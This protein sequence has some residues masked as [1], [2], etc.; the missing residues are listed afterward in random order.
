MSHDRDGG[1]GRRRFLRQGLAGA[2]GLALVDRAWPAAS[3]AVSLA[4]AE[5]APGVHNML[6]VGEDAVFLSHLPMFQR[7]DRSGSE[8]VSPAQHPSTPRSSPRAHSPANSMGG[9]P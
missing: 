6:V 3:P 8:F 1:V 9:W 5:D 4:A 2:V 7:L